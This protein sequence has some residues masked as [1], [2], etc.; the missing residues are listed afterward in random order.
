ML[1]TQRNNVSLKRVLNLPLLV[2]YGL[3]VTVGAG[4]FALIGE[5]LKI[6]GDRAPFAFLVAGIIA[7]ATGISYALLS[8]VY[9][10]AGGE[11]VYVKMSLGGNV[12]RVV[13]YAITLTAIVSSA[14]IAIAF[15]GYLGTLVALPQPLLVIGI[16]A[17][18]TLV[19]C[20]GVK[21][22]VLFASVITLLEVGT[23]AIIIY[24]GSSFL[25]EPNTLL[26]SITPPTS[27]PALTATLSATII[28]FFAFVGFEDMVN[29][30]EETV[31]PTKVMPRAIGITL[32]ITVIL[33]V[34]IA[35]IAAALPNRQEITGSAAPLATLYSSVTGFSGKPISAMAAIAM[36]NGILVQI[37]MASRVIYGMTTERLAPSYLGILHPKRQT[38]VRAILLVS[39]L[40]TVLAL[41]F[42]LV[43]LAQV[44][45]L[46]ILFVFFMVNISL[47]RIGSKKNAHIKLNKWRNWGLVGALLTFLLFFFEI[48]RLINI[49]GIN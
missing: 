3:G 36:V 45:S 6:S 13:G 28:A 9:P 17:M 20:L 41:L 42:P 24:F 30:A 38:P 34:M 11:A 8:S 12:A 49:T 1:N 15:G 23:L 18:L 39:L 37:I 29:M 4:I 19:A 27:L 26:K 47:W 14:V 40:I 43:H 10:R 35:T 22:S 46:I 44:T 7:G 21:E 16:L 32:A 31:N 5:V 25:A 33:Y 48:F 2:F